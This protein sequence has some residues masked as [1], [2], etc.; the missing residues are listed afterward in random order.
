MENVCMG[1]CFSFFLF[2]PFP[3]LDFRLGWGKISEKYT[4]YLILSKL[5]MAHVL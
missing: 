3:L 5:E 4:S 2:P 1:Y